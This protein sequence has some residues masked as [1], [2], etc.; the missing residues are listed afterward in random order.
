MHLHADVGAGHSTT[1]MRTTP[2]NMSARVFPT[3]GP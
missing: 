3:S 2:L 1:L